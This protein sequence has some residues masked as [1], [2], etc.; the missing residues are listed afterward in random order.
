MIEKRKMEVKGRGQRSSVC[1]EVYGMFNKKEDFK[2]R[3]IPKDDEQKKRILS[4][5]GQSFL[6][7]SLDKID[8]ETVLCAFEEKKFN[9]GEAV[10]TQGDEGDVLYYIEQGELDC[11][12]TFKKEDGDVYL[13]TYNPGEA[14]G[15]LA[16][17]YNAPRAAT[18][19]A[20]TDSILWALDRETFKNI[21]Q[22]AAM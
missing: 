16:L 13:K 1:A 12:K 18:I 11:Y 5:I 20:K 7:S 4:K 21:V 8:M 3:I 6:F 14:F 15:E 19:K 22:D 9:S 17:L 2:P 10:I